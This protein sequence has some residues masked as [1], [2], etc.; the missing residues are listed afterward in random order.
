MGLLRE[1]K[2]LKIVKTDWK[3]NRGKDYEERIVYPLYET[4]YLSAIREIF[5]TALKQKQIEEERGK[6]F[7]ENEKRNILSFIGR[8]GSG[9]TTSMNEFCKILDSLDDETAKKWW[10]DN[11]LEEEKEKMELRGKN[12][13]FHILSPIDASL[14]GEKEDFFELIL[15]KIY[16]EFEKDIPFEC[17]TSHQ[18]EQSR[19]IAGKL[20]SILDGYF[21]TQ[22]KSENNENERNLASIMN[23]M[24][25]T[26]DIERLIGELVELLFELKGKR[27]D[28]EYIV[29]AIDD[30]DLNIAH[31]YEMLDQLQK[32][33]S[34]YK[35][36]ILL[37]LDYN[38][39]QL[40]C[41]EHF[42][43]AL[44]CAADK[45]GYENH[46]S[47]LANDY[48]KKIFHYSQR[49]YMPDIRKLSKRIEIVLTKEI[50]R[51]KIEEELIEVKCFLMRKIAE[52]MNIY[53]DGCG[54]KRHFC[55]LD[56]VRELVT[57]NDFLES[58]IQVQYEKLIPVEKLQENE[59]EMIN[60]N[61]EILR[62]YDQNHERFNE[63]ILL[64]LAENTLT[65][66]Q[67]EAFEKLNDRGIERRAM[68][69]V[70]MEKNEHGIIIKNINEEEYSYGSL[71][72]KIYTWGRDC[73]EDK[74]FISCVLASLTSE[75]VR[76]YL[77]YRYNKQDK[78]DQRYRKRLV[79]FLGQ[80]F[81][82]SW[83]GEA[84]PKIRQAEFGIIGYNREAQVN[85]LDIK[86]P[87]DTLEKLDANEL[88]NKEG[89]EKWKDKLERWL[90]KEEILE[91]L[92]VLDLLCVRREGE[93]FKGLDFFF[94]YETSNEGDRTE[95]DDNKS[96]PKANTGERAGKE[97][98]IS[99]KT[100][101]ESKVWITL[102]IMAFVPK[103]LN[104]DS[105]K[106][107]FH[108]NVTEQLTKVLSEYLKL[109]GEN[110][111]ELKKILG[112]LICENSEF[113][114]HMRE[115]F[116]Y[117]PAFPFYDLDLSYNVW[118]RVRRK[119]R[120]KY[121]EAESILKYIKLIYDEVN[122]C[123]RAEKEFYFGEGKVKNFYLSN[124]ENCP[125]IKM[126]KEVKDESKV[127]VRLAEALKNMVLGSKLAESSGVEAEKS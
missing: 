86:V 99:G 3:K 92:Q 15:V 87:F 41:K 37:T 42:Y 70:G 68:Y 80:S 65:Y 73:F 108:K 43:R 100:D 21:S 14:L 39:M 5:E 31:G 38:Q 115:N 118:K 125:Y 7:I 120:G 32:Y 53:Y 6:K 58:L 52:C 63:D 124:F 27:Y 116:V 60:S 97:F 1:T 36:I 67:K 103:S 96:A 26:H 40:V 55:E 62:I 102:D 19:G 20:Q 117:E 74:P 81:G 13:K 10:I 112:G 69:F 111:E 101:E 75:M 29:I 64:R 121:I 89:E 25:E 91:T 4:G 119:Y 57:Y 28:Y 18:I 106:D 47:N 88:Q 54:L 51:G 107:R 72:E 46:I 12:F 30:L 17:Q 85:R 110:K 45:E 114:K 76:E 56:T 50:E 9:K 24:A 109:N 105:E 48:M 49:V 77:N 44:K 78:Q 83:C 84:F 34:Y 22:G 59:E 23:F 94:S 8:R 79:Q 11:A 71:L 16:K 104:Y 93:E 35:I 113:G 2:K 66:Q 90:K 33:F 123:L 95:L 82:N 61:A 122:E 127:T 98:R 126:V